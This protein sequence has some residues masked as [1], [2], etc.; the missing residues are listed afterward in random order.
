ME[1]IREL[2]NYVFTRNKFLLF[3]LIIV[4]LTVGSLLVLGSGSAVTPFIYA[5]F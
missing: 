2:L 4:L 1:M 3:P 5:L